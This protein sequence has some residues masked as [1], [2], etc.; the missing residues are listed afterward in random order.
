MRK[1]VF[2]ALFGT[3]MF[4]SCKKDEV[5]PEPTPNTT[6]S[7]VALGTD[8]SSANEIV[9]L[10]AHT[11]ALQTGYT[12]LYVEVKDLNNDP[13]TNASVTF[14]PLMD[15]GTMTHACP[16]EQPFFNADKNKYEGMVV[17]TMPS[18][19]GNWTLDVLVNGNPVTFD[20]SIADAPTKV[21]GSYLG[22][23]GLSYIVT[24]VPPA[25]WTVGMNDLEILV[26]RKESMMSFPAENELEI[27]L[28][29]EMVSMGH[30]SPNNI[31]PTLVGNGHY[32]GKVNLT[33][34]GDWRFHLALSKNGTLI[35]ADAFLDILF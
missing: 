4:A 34:T 28:D 31:S 13:I 11:T 20:L 26:H 2:A 35:H 10:Y 21:V 17:F 12:K 9:T 3:L 29:P 32:K 24:L 33:M 16:V 6:E 19:A 30:G 8:T 22:T 15:M 14:A 25:V 23:D 7:M 5:T 1:I 18:T 27:V